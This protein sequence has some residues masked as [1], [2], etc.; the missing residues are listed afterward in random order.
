MPRAIRVSAFFRPSTFGL[1]IC[2]AATLPTRFQFLAALDKNVGAH[3]R[4]ANAPV[5][6]LEGGFFC[7]DLPLL[8]CYEA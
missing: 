2:P 3:H 7:P 1:R 5:W 8:I 6:I 4:L